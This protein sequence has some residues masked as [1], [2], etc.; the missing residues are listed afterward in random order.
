MPSRRNRRCCADDLAVGDHLEALDLEF[1]QRA[2]EGA[3]DVGV[4]GLDR[5]NDV[6]RDDVMPPKEDDAGGERHFLQDCAAERDGA[7]GR[8]WRR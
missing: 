3:D 1:L 7:A 4:N 2:G 8:Q 6:R 5:A